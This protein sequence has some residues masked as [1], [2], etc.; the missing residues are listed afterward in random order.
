MTR[1]RPRHRGVSRLNLRRRRFKPFQVTAVG[2]SLV[3]PP[4][5]D[6]L[7]CD[8]LVNG[9][10]QAD[11]AAIVVGNRLLILPV[12]AD[13]LGDDGTQVEPDQTVWDLLWRRGCLIHQHR[14]D[15]VGALGASQPTPPVGRGTT[16][17]TSECFPGALRNGEEAEKR[18]SDD[19]PTAEARSLRGRRS[20]T[21]AL[22]AVAVQ[23]RST[24]TGPNAAI[25]PLGRSA[26][27][28]DVQIEPGELV[29][30]L[31][32]DSSQSWKLVRVLAGVEPVD[33]GM[34]L[35]DGRACDPN[36]PEFARFLSAGPGILLDRVSSPIHR[37]VVDEVAYPMMAY[38]VSADAART[39][40]ADTLR[41]VLGRPMDG[42]SIADLDSND[43]RAVALARALA[44]SWGVRILA[45]PLRGI[46]PSRHHIVR[47]YL[48]DLRRRG[49]TTVVLT[50]DPEIISLGDRCLVIDGGIVRSISAR[51]AA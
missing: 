23:F 21:M 15:A 7:V 16:L 50:D 14:F 24:S 10:E 34:V 5:V 18:A 26:V 44:G 12:Q 35:H 19:R 29:V 37:G 49:S 3:L 2:R 38:G 43:R 9:L 4:G 51:A 48:H 17:P 6:E 20:G 25:R 39:H 11:V 8:E 36:D 27:K 30:V 41:Q 47:Q 28:C 22:E 45:D 42:S 13:L 1:R 46:D 32:P 31:N 40:A 33:D